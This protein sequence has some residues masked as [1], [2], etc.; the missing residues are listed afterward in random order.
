MSVVLLAAV[1]GPALCSGAIRLTCPAGEMRD[2][3]AGRLVAA[4]SG[5][6][7]ALAVVL[8][9]GVATTGPVDA[10][11]APFGSDHLVGLFAN[12]VGAVFLLL[13]TGVSSV[14][15]VFAAR[16]LRGD[17]EAGRFALLAGLLTSTTAA[18][19][20]ASTLIGLALAWTATGVVLCWL[21]GLYGELP[22]ARA[23]VR[24]TMRAFVIGD[25]AL[26]LGVLVATAHWGAL[27][28]RDLASRAP[29]FAGAPT[30]SGVVACLLVAAAAARSAQVPFHGWLPSTLAAPTP[31]SALL[32]AGVVNGGGM[33]LI[34]LSPVVGTSAL[35]TH[36]AFVVGA[37]SVIAGTASMLVRSDVKGS[38]ALSTVGQMGFMVMTCGLGAY[39]AAAFHLVA[40]GM[41]KASLFLGSGAAVARHARHHYAPKAAALGRAGLAGRAAVAIAV[42]ALALVAATSAFPPPVGV[43]AHGTPA[44]LGFAWATSA[45]AGWRWLQ[46]RSLRVGVLTHLMIVVP[47]I[48]AYLAGVDA[49]AR[50]LAP[51]LIGAGTTAAS[52]WLLGPVILLLGL[53]SLVRRRPIAVAPNVG[54]ALYVAALNA[55]HRPWPAPRAQK[56]REV[57]RHRERPSSVAEG[58]RP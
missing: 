22:A 42:P 25:G 2:A 29:D 43:G 48:F 4:A 3:L 52:P 49:M 15:Q 28:L 40:H 7:F 53:V 58:S 54:P 21:L 18:T 19:A 6:A 27:D 55:G 17:A 9:V 14:V 31:V 36:M 13:V 44:L 24:R 32:H 51:A 57:S 30:V 33:L 26:W 5:A 35:A 1:L 45:W 47:A 37:L 8:A 11:L 20:T 16:Y 46:S 34:A 10:V 23:G 38:L 41:Y 56:G 39:A 12:Q 50:A